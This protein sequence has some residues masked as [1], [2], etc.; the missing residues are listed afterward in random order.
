MT[1]AWC[2][3][4][5]FQIATNRYLRGM[6]W[7]KAIWIHT[8]SGYIMY[9]LTIASA[10]YALNAFEWDFAK[11]FSDIPFHFGLAIP[12]I[13]LTFF[14]VFGGSFL[15]IKSYTSAKWNTKIVLKIRAFHR[16]VGFFFILLGHVTVI[17]MAGPFQMGMLVFFVCLLIY[18]EYKYRKDLKV[19]IPMRKF[20]PNEKN[21]FTQEQFDEMIKD[22][23]QL[24]VL[25]D[26]VLD[27]A[28]F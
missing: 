15:K 22:G 24:V 25:D 10:Y 18:F 4:A 26:L 20:A 6:M 21:I 19:E 17:T 2:F 12:V 23:R 7:K 16:Y 9:G 27:V 13:T 14:I 28:K 11:I 5:F 8:L 1:L 3:F